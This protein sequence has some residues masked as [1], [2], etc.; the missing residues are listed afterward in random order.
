MKKIVS[1]LASLAM[2]ASLAA[3]GET[4]EPTPENGGDTPGVE[5]P[6]DNEEEEEEEEEPAQ[7]VTDTTIVVGNSAANSGAYAPV[8]VPFN[9]GIEAYFAMINDGG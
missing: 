1:I 9:A 4:D 6:A 8:G 7:G 3:C 2:V 5:T